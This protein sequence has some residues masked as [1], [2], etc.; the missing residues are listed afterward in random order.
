MIV[1]YLILVYSVCYTFFLNKYIKCYAFTANNWASPTWFSKWV[2][3]SLLWWYSCYVKRYPLQYRSRALISEQ[4]TTWWL[5]APAS[6]APMPGKYPK[7]MTSQ[8]VTESSLGCA[9]AW[10]AIPTYF[11]NRLL[12]KSP[13]GIW[14][15]L[16][17]SVIYGKC[18]RPL[19]LHFVCNCYNFWLQL[20]TSA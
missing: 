16:K 15:G 17:Q 14:V 2:K 12:T 13:I 18:F 9:S 1:M 11:H 4:G 20:Q 19:L 7:V 3:P 10:Y 8:M 5:T 6:P